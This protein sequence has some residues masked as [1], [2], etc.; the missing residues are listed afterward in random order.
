MRR[1]PIKR[2]LINSLL[3]VAALLAAVWFGGRFWLAGSLMPL[4][5]QVD[6]PGLAAPVEVLFDGRGIPQ[7]YAESD[8]DALTALGWLHASER[9]FQMELLRKVARGEI[10]EIVGPAGLESDVLHRQYGFAR[11]IGMDPP[12]IEAETRRLIAAY[13]DGINARIVSDRTLPPGF[14]LLGH[15][16]APWTVDDVLTLAY[17]QTWY[18]TTLVQRL[19]EAWRDAARADEDAPDWLE[20]LPRWGLP[21]IP[22]LSIY[23]GVDAAPAGLPTNPS[24]IASKIPALRMTEASNTWVVAPE[25]SASGEALHASDPHLDYTAAPELW[26]AAGIRSAETLDLVGVT[27]PGLPFVTMGHNGRIAFAFTVAP[28]DMFEFYRFALDD[29]GRPIG[30][31]GPFGIVE[32]EE[33]FAVRD[34][35]EPV[36]R[37]VATTRYGIVIDHAGD[38]IEVLHWAGFDL[39]VGDLIENGLALNRA[40]DFDSFRAAASDMGALS[41]NWSYSDRE[42]NIGYVQSTPIPLRRHEDFYTTL[43]GADRRNHWAGF[44]PPEQRPWALN[45][46]QGWLA[47]SNNHA[48]LDAPWPMPGFYKHLRMR[49]SAAWLESKPVFNAG[50][51][52]AMQMDY[53]SDRALSWKDWL[54]D[55][56]AGTGRAALAEE[57]RG[58][59]GVMRADSETAGLF[60]LWWQYLARHLFEDTALADWHHGRTLLDEWM[61]LPPEEFELAAMPREEAAERALEDALK[62]PRMPLGAIQTL[63]IEHPLAAAGILDAWLNLT[64]GPYPIGGGPGSLNVTYHSFDEKNIHLHARAGASMRFV[65]DWSDPD[66]FTL[67][68][69]LGQSG[70]PSSP[71][72]DDQ[73]EDF[74]GGRPWTVPFGREAVEQRAESRLELVP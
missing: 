34:H 53:T 13:V 51:M 63:T 64:R 26:Y 43:A 59:D 29:Q 47:N 18:P 8:A 36:R 2:I 72:F 11:R 41:V 40:G 1:F 73:L 33:T 6:L 30:P 57:L 65:M 19:A 28:V 9:L 21:T 74:L 12:E 44:V 3:S 22:S 27:V 49:R 69:T 60:T 31:D 46:G 10:S 71:H 32:R 39:P 24:S 5:G 48:A 52:H 55:I 54:A 20:R 56:A 23:R 35:A 17:Y 68:L 37:T 61:H 16:P 4:E 25:K 70:H 58:W 66:A 67:N 62:Q 45:P 38:S 42:G 15:A 50:D 7:I 14:V